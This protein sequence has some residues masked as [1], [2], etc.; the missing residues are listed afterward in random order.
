MTILVLGA[1]GF[2]GQWVC[3]AIAERL[4]QATLLPSGREG[5]LAMDITK[6]DSVEQLIAD[7][8]PTH[9]LNLA[10]ISSPPACERAPARAFAVNATGPLNLATALLRHARQARLI[11]V[12]SSEVY[13][14]A[15][16]A[17]IPVCE[18]TQP[19]PNTIYG[20]SKYAGEIALR[21]LASRGLRVLILRPFPH[22]GPGQ[23]PDFA[24]S[25]FAR[26]I[27]VAEQQSPPPPISVGRLDAVRDITDVRD[28][29]RAYLAALVDIDRLPNAIAINLC[30]GTGHRLEEILARLLH[31]AVVPL[32]WQT[33]PELVRPVDTLWAVGDASRAKFL[34]GWEPAI[35]LEHSLRD[36]LA[37]ARRLMRS[38]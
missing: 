17:K 9:V 6:P 4:P 7:T 13:G 36:V 32:R 27:A 2:V 29:V 31:L 38:S 19:Q 35:P 37:D 10:A 23:R 8:Q 14:A 22:I 21:A 34:L 16:E 1:S 18:D 15:F 25:A 26:R 30:S 12:S 24:V 28:I 33:D 11:H 5:P 3:Q 20:A